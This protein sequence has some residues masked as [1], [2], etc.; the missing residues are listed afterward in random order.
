MKNLEHDEILKTYA[1]KL[2][3][4]LFF[5]CEITLVMARFRITTSCANC[6]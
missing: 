2:I 4:F 6:L 1:R 3:D 5:F